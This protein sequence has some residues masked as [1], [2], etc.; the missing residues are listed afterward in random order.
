MNEHLNFWRTWDTNEKGFLSILA[1]IFII[2][3]L[4]AIWAY[5]RDLETIIKWDIYTELREK[6]VEN[7]PFYFENLQFSS[8]T[9]VWYVV[10]RFLPSLAKVP[11]WVFYLLLATGIVGISFI[12]S[13]FSKLNQKGFLLGLLILLVFV[14]SFRIENIFGVN[15]NYYSFGFYLLASG[16]FYILNS[17]FRSKPLWVHITIWFVFWTLILISFKLMSRESLPLISISAYGLSGMF[18][19]TFVLIFFT[20]HESFAGMVYLISQNIQKGKSALPQFF[21]VSLIFVL[22]ALLI[23]FENTKTL[24]ASP[25]IISPIF[26]FV[27]QVILGFWG[28]KKF[29]DHSEMFS[30]RQIGAWAYLGFSLVGMGTVAFIYLSGNDPLQDLFED[31]VSIAFLVMS[32][33]FFVYVLMNYFQIMKQGLAVHKV[34]YKAPYSKLWYSRLVGFFAI[35]GLFTLKNYYSYFQFQ[36]GVNNTIA[37]YH[38]AENKFKLAETFY[39]TGANFDPFNHKSNLS[40]ASMAMDVGDKSSAGFFFNQS[41]QKI[42]NALAYAGLSHSLENE[43]RYFESIFELQKGLKSFPK[44]SELYTNLAYLQS[45]AKLADSV[46]FNLNKANS[47]CRNCESTESNLLAFWIEN[48][49]IEMLASKTHETKSS[50]ISG[51]ANKTAIAKILGQNLEVDLPKLAKDSALN[52]SQLAI[53]ANTALNQKNISPK[54]ITTKLLENLMQNPRN[55]AFTG[56]LELAQVQQLY[57]RENKLQGLKAWALLAN[58]DSKLK[59]LLNQNLGLIYFKEG[60]LQKG[61]ESLQKSGD[62]TSSALILKQDLYSKVD[63]K[64]QEK[65]LEHSKN[66]SLKN[67]KE[68]LA[69]APVNPYLINTVSNFLLKNKKDSEAYNLAFYATDFLPEHPLVWRSIFDSALALSQYEYASEALLKLKTKLSSTEYLAL[70]QKLNDKKTQ[71]INF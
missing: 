18:L 14:L 4:A 34:L 43:N 32:L 42:P 44:Q 37:D 48:A 52:V 9:P 22:N 12:M 6:I 8:S 69:K 45:R 53:I 67:Y 60:L 13:A 16:V 29:T 20:A 30:F 3:A 21:G 38:L 10:E 49:K 41:L 39:K 24:E 54:G 19:L 66:L 33:G 46:Y 11:T 25:Y 71:S 36:A 2:T 27:I 35:L 61:I 51:M 47:L 31:M 63:K 64:L 5:S 55:E 1:S 58:A 50:G 26:I 28:L 7:P 62:S 68:V 40:L 59:P 65:A 57:L 17:F 70:V 23:Y 56:P 15:H